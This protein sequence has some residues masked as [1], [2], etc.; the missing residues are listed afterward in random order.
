VLA[1]FERGQVHVALVPRGAEGGAGMLD[2]AK[3]MQGVLETKPG[4]GPWTDVRFYR[5]P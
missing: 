5:A 4:T 1:T 3:S 2:L